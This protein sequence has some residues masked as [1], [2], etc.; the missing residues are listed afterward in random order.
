MYSKEGRGT[1]PDRR[2][3][4]ARAWESSCA[5]GFLLRVTESSRRVWDLTHLAPLFLIRE[6]YLWEGARWSAAEGPLQEFWS[7]GGLSE[8]PQASAGS[9][10]H[11]GLCEGRQ[12]S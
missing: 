3:A 10:Q 6:K 1:T 4:E 11:S 9:N 2:G 7:A 12:L 5:S 8:K